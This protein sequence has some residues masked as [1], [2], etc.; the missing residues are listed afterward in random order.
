MGE[1]RGIILIVCWDNPNIS[2][3]LHHLFAAHDVQTRSG[4][5][6]ESARE[7][8]GLCIGAI[9]RGTLHPSGG[10]HIEETIEDDAHHFVVCACEAIG[11]EAD[12]EARVALESPS[13][14]R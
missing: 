12:A 3:G 10:Y 2:L 9:H 4:G 11:R 6:G 13:Q 14:A 5:G 1:K 7:V 8:V